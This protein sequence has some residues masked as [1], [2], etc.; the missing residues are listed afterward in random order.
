MFTTQPYFPNQIIGS[1]RILVGLFMIYH[2]LEVF[3]S[4]LMQEYSNWDAFK[5]D[6]GY[7]LVYLGKA[8]ELISGVSLFLGLFTRVGA[9]LLI[10][11]L[12][13]IAFIFG[14]GRIWYEEQ[15]PFLFV[16]FGVLYLFHGPGSWSLDKFL[17]DNKD[18]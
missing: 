2:G 13:Y 18:K 5:S 7:Y 15:H 12:S 4:T 16:M 8:T 14:Q 1:L 11:A 10:F 17:F 6:V 3:D 9:L